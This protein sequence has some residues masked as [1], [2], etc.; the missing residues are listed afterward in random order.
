MISKL[1]LVREELNVS[2]SELALRLG[3]SQ[4]TV[5]RLEQSEAKGSISLNTLERAAAA[6]GC[7]IE[8]RISSRTKK[9]IEKYRGFKRTSSKKHK[10]SELA[11]S[12]KGEEQSLNDS[13]TEE[14]RVLRACSLSDFLRDLK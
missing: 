9:N 7:D 12:M 1:K 3:V 8:I 14:E 13:L 4:S 2:T 10:R 11:E 6:L 5:V